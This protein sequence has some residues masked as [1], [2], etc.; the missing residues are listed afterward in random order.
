MYLQKRA[1]ATNAKVRFDK[2]NKYMKYVD[3]YTF[4]FSAARLKMHQ[5]ILVELCKDF[6]STLR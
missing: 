6:F 2:L 3:K 1:E 5:Q 4:N